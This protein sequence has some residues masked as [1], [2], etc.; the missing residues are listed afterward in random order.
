M[1]PYITFNSRRS[2][3][4]GLIISEIKRKKGAKKR[5]TASVPFSSVV[6]DFSRACGKYAYNERSDTYVFALSAAD[7]QELE[8]KI[9]K[10]SDWLLDAPQ[11]DMWDSTLLDRHFALCSCT[12]LTPSYVNP[13]TA[14]LTATFA[15]YAYMIADNTRP[16]YYTATGTLTAQTYELTF[17]EGSTP[18]F[19]TATACTV[20]YN[21][22]DYTI[23]AN[24][25]RYRISDIVFE[26]GTN[27][28]SIQ[29]SGELKIETFEEV[30]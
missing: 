14:R 4:F 24:S 16:A 27:S 19:T 15:S 9:S 11:G 3:E 20:R 17:A 1:R 6:Y 29:G 18:Y 26:R 30:H 12:D 5:V 7:P 13:S 10:I 28:F 2:D 25:I 22:T 21:G 8:D 23:P